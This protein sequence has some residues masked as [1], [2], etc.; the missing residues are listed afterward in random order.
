MPNEPQRQVRD[1]EPLMIAWKAHQQTE[2]FRNTLHWAGASNLGQLWACFAAGFK[3][4]G[5]EYR[6]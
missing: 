3:A 4:G 2:E 5:G 6:P 1:D